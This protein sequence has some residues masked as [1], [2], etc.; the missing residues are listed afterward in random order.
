MISGEDGAAGDRNEKPAPVLV[1]AIG[2]SASALTR[3]I[4][5]GVKP[6]LVASAVMAIMGQR[7]MRMLCNECKEA[8]DPT[9][10]ELK[11]IALSLEDMKGRPL[12]RAVGCENCGGSGYYGR[13][14]IYELMEMSTDL[15]DM[16][17]NTKP[18]QELR[19]K[20]RSEGMVTLQE[21][22]VRKLLAG[23]TSIEDILRVTHSAEFV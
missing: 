18:T 15:R 23:V 17:F 21:D 14:G 22:A 6:F 12:H 3:L 13:K 4:D 1:F 9:E 11:Q 7:L 2:G 19:S 16:T 20:A 8:Y 10:T 5:M